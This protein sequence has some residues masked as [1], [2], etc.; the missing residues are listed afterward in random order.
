[1]SLTFPFR[2][3]TPA[4]H[5]DEE[6]DVD[7]RALVDAV[8]GPVLLVSSSG[9]HL[10]ELVRLVENWGLGRER[11]HWCVPRTTQTEGALAGEAVSWAPPVE[12]R[13]LGRAG[14]NFSTAQAVHHRV[15]P[16]LVVSAGA[17]QAVPHLVVAA[18]HRTPIVYVESVARL[19][20][21]SLTGRVAMHLPGAHLFNQAGAWDGRWM[22]TDDVYSGMRVVAHD[23][24]R[25]GVRRAVVAL[26]TEHFGFGRAVEQ[27]LV[28]LAE[29]PQITWQVGTT[30][31]EVGGSQLQRWLAP[32]RLAAAMRGS[33]AVVVHGG[34]GSILAALESGHVP[35]AVARTARWS[36]HCDDHQL[37]M[38]ESLAERGLCVLVRPDERLG[39]EHLEQVVG[40]R[41]ET[42]G[43]A[44][45]RAS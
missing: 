8:D 9:G 24:P 33:D 12:S 18:L 10:A 34:A 2:H 31:Y 38:C 26:G 41:V 6:G 37:R 13:Q 39:H 19:D 28:A 17:A 44:S 35:I 36:E 21:P 25:G 20:G 45:S 11:R 42:G 15:R 23:R 1:M 3:T 4:T 14:L 7:A 22:P 32:Q 27:A 16:R 40:V 43:A 30:D 5:W 29:C